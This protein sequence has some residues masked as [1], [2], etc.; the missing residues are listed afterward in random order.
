MNQRRLQFVTVLVI[1][2]LALFLNLDIS[3]FVEDEGLY[4]A[5]IEQTFKHENLFHLD[6]YGQ[7]YLNK[8]PLFFW[9][10]SMA[11][12]NLSPLFGSLEVALRL[13]E[14]LFSLGTLLLT[15]HIGA[16][17]YTHLTVPTICSV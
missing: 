3:L 10:E 8:P 2:L 12:T 15:Y 14:S 5:I 4:A 1:G 9:M 17:S 7:T 16:V 6:L 11:S 13:P